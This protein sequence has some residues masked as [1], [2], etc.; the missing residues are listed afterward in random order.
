MKTETQY[1]HN[2]LNV[3][4]DSE[5]RVLE[6][7][8]ATTEKGGG[9]HTS[10]KGS[11]DEQADRIEV[12]QRKTDWVDVRDFGAVGDGVTDDTNAI[13]NAINTL[14]LSRNKVLYIPAGTYLISNSANQVAIDL[15]QNV[16][17]IGESKESVKLV[18]ASNQAD[19][20]TRMVTT[21]GN[22][23][24]RN[25]TLDGNRNGNPNGSEHM[26]CIFIYDAD[27]VL[28]EHCN[29][30]NAVGDGV[31]ITG[32][33][34]IGSKNI[35]VQFCHSEN[36]KRSACVVEQVHNVKILNNTLIS[37]RSCIH[38]EPF[39]TIELS[40]AVVTGNHIIST[41]NDPNAG[42]SVSLRGS[43]IGAPSFRNIIFENNYIDSP[44]VKVLIGWVDHC[45]VRNNRF[46][47]SGINAWYRN[48]NLTLADNEIIGTSTTD[49]DVISITHE[50]NETSKYVRIVNNKITAQTGNGITLKGCKHVHVKG[51]VITRVNISSFTDFGVKVWATDPMVNIVIEEN[52]ISNF[53]RGVYTINYNQHDISDIEIKGNYFHLI[54]ET[55]ILIYG[56]KQNLQ[57]VENH[58]VNNGTAR[59]IDLRSSFN[60]V[61]G[62]QVLANMIYNWRH[63]ISMETVGS[64]VYIGL[65]V[66]YNVIDSI[67]GTPTSGYKNAAIEFYSN[68]P[69]PQKFTLIGNTITN[70]ITDLV[71]PSS[72]KYCI[73]GTY[74]QV[75]LY[76]G[77]GSPEGILTLPVGSIY[78]N[79]T[80]GTSTTIYVKQTGTG[81]TG[82][83]AK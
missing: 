3:P 22:N 80:G 50:G 15:K 70:S 18:L 12:L 40:G 37:E 82:W 39:A 49:I 42:Y 71:L 67:K 55:G 21:R 76:T 9:D 60:G 53:N 27:N 11:F 74:G 61:T 77:N 73:G 44:N 45:I 57:I 51:N 41:H 2:R 69:A 35:T 34:S 36:N 30:T 1:E 33:K 46:K 64:N 6:T 4:G 10:F 54:S 58:M 63:G 83:I 29:L 62:F 16:S 31:S 75:G 79:N 47:V 28:V 68:D 5:G 13:N 26:H 23:T 72:L 7:Q 20:W 38:F 65:T 32:S 24:I 8:V 17:L 25:L 66:S 56:V 81:N 78:L 59:A 19:T 14:S 52:D 43:G 48:E